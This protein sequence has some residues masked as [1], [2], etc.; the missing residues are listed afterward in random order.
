MFK[1]VTWFSIGVAAGAL[2][3]AVTYVRGRELA[4]ERM[5]ESVQDAAGRVVRATDSGLRAAVG[6]T[7]AQIGEWR[8]AVDETRRTRR[9]A[10]DL[11][12]RQLDRSGL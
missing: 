2:G 9:E 4:R 11:L 3:A 6:R 10:E 8:S 12:Q 7:S 5:P 1:R